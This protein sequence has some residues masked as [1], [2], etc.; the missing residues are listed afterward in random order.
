M[1]NET[2][3]AALTDLL[4]GVE[5]DRHSL[6]DGE[7]KVEALGRAIARLRGESAPEG[8]AVACEECAG[9]GEV[10][11]YIDPYQ[12]GDVSS[13]VRK[14]C[15]DCVQ[16]P[17]APAPVAG[18]VPRS[19]VEKAREQLIRMGWSV[20]VGADAEA[21]F[22][23]LLVALREAPVAGEAVR[24]TDAWRYQQICRLIDAGDSSLDNAIGDAYN[25]GAGALELF[26]DGL[27]VPV[28]DI[29]TALAQDRASQA[30]AAGGVLAEIERELQR[31]VAKFPTWPTDPL[32][33][34]GVV[35]EETGE[36]AK[37]VLQAVYEPHKSTQ[38]DVRAEAIQT[39]AMAIRFVQSLDAGAYSW[40]PGAQHSAAPTPAAER[41]VE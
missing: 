11:E 14:P 16:Q 31:A 10:V 12:R 25:M 24:G 5:M 9:S 37:A 36:L 23:R 17:V 2:D 19:L 40:T 7:A 22:R 38:A 21:V 18:D 20:D 34:S 13:P 1:S 39:A 35:M 4:V 28:A 26:L 41:E 3:I 8:Q 15:P 29:E 32:H 33:A 27:H 30:G 6:P